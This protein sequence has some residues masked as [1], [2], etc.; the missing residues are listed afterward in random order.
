MWRTCPSRQCALARK[1]AG[2]RG[3]SGDHDTLDL[4]DE[5]FP[6]RER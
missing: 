2:A 6:L 3:G 4:L 1:L 5:A